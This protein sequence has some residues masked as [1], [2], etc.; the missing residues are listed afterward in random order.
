VHDS[1]L[2]LAV[3]MEEKR[4]IVDFRK[5]KVLKVYWTFLLGSD[6]LMRK[7][8]EKKEEVGRGG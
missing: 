3:G 1:G 2:I 4:T 6:R 5:S 7:C 8:G